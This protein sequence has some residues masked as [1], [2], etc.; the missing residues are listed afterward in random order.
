MGYRESFVSGSAAMSWSGASPE[1]I[2][3]H[4]DVGTEFFRT[5]L[6]DELVYSA[7]R[8]QEPLTGERIATTLEEAQVAKLD[9]HLGA[10]NAGVGRT[11]LDIG[12]G[13]GA[14]MRRA[15]ARY[16]AKEAS[17]ITQIGRASC[18]ERV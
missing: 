7:G 3:F 9:F 12:C 5:W 1:A 15:I 17:G 13:W 6:G 2:R 8:W 4:Y 11:L 16:G 10:V 18:R 14:L